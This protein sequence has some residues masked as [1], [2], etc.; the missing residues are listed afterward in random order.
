MLFNIYI[1]LKGLGGLA[2]VPNVHNLVKSD[3]IVSAL[4]QLADVIESKPFTY[5]LEITQIRLEKVEE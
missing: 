3:S 5:D 4:R 2:E 1:T